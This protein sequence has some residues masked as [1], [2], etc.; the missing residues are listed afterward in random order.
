MADIKST[1]EIANKWARV[2]P[3]R[4]PD[5]AAGVKN[6]KRSWSQG[7][8]DAAEAYNQGVTEAIAGGRFEKGVAAAGDGKWSRKAQQVGTQRFGPGVQAA[9]GDYEAGFAPY[10][11]VIAGVNLPPRGAKGDP[12]NYERVK[13]IGDAL[14]TAK[15]GGGPAAA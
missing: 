4:A 11:Q 6:P 15:V 8:Q 10:A 1:Q 7:A 12:R 9:K 3:Q 2:T 13:A 14:H 5:Y